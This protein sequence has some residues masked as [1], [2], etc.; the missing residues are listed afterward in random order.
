MNSAWAK[1]IFSGIRFPKIRTETEI[2]VSYFFSLIFLGT[3][4]LMLPFSWAGKEKLE[5][6]D[7]FFTSAS[8]VC[9]TGL[10]TVDTSLYSRFGQ[11]VIIFLIQTGGLGLISFSSFYL[12]IPFKKP[13]MKGSRLIR[14]YYLDSIEYEPFDIIKQII[15]MTFSVEAIGVFFL[16]FQFLEAGVENPFFV[17]LFHSVSAFC[18][19]GFSTFPDSFEN[20]RNNPVVN[21]TV[22]LLIILGGIGFVVF[23]DIVKKILNRKRHL[24]VHSKLVITA[25]S[26]L[27]M[28]GAAVFFAVESSY[29]LEGSGLREKILVSFFQSVTTRT[30]GF[31]TVV[32]REMNIVS[33]MVMIP[34]MFIGGAPGSIAGGIKVTTFSVLFFVIVRRM[35]ERKNITVFKRNIPSPTIFR[36]LVFIIKAFSILCGG[37]FIFALSEN[38]FNP[39]ASFTVME[40]IF[41]CFSA[42]GTVGLS[43]G[44]TGSLSIPGKL[45][46]ILI[47]VTGRF[48]LLIVVMNLFSK[49][50]N[51]QYDY[52]NEE[53]LIG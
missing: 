26:I 53:I 12:V 14:G 33:Q 35:D 4:L 25:T 39:Q 5:L 31:N 21:A 49:K 37:I 40:I 43:L 19:A 27:I 6:V 30:A 34:L 24:A 41:E 3:F 28:A 46:I 32:I 29:L 44:I 52:P 23:R 36:A 16:Y 2:I 10:V 15:L 8:A 18:N 22:M 45:I 13:S 42:F 11:G 9:V 48:G 50:R 7:A 47:M 38:Y 17:S 20:Y 51:I 1:M